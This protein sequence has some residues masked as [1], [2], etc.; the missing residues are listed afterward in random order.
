MK[1]LIDIL[2]QKI[3]HYNQIFL[4]K[5]EFV[6]SRDNMPN[7]S[8]EASLINIT[9]QDIHFFQKSLFTPLTTVEITFL[10][11]ISNL[12]EQQKKLI[13]ML[14]LDEDQKKII[15]SINLKIMSTLDFYSDENISK[16]E[17]E[18]KDY[19]VLLTKVKNN[20]MNLIDEWDLIKSLLDSENIRLEDKINIIID[21]NTKNLTILENYDSDLLEQDKVIEEDDLQITNLSEE[22]VREIFN[23]YKIDWNSIEPIFKEKLLKYGT[24]EKIEDILACLKDN[25]LQHIFELHEVLTKVLLFSNVSDINKVVRTLEENGIWHLAKEQPTIFF[26]SVKE[27]YKGVSSTRRGPSGKGKS[28]ISGSLTNFM[29]NVELLEELDISI[30]Y[31]GEKCSTFFIHSNSAARRTLKLL[32]LYGLKVDNSDILKDCIYVLRSSSKLL[33]RLDIAIENDCLEYAGSN[34][35]RISNNDVNFYRIKYAKKMYKQG[36][37][38]GELS[39]FKVYKNG[40]DRLA[41]SEKFYSRTNKIYGLNPDDTFELYGAVSYESENKEIYDGII[42]ASDNDSMSAMVLNDPIIQQLDNLYYDPINPFIYNFNGV[43]ISR[44]KVLRHYETLIMDPNIEPSY[45]LL[46]YVV[47]LFSMI[48]EKELNMIEECINKIKFVKGK[49][50]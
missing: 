40:S 36:N 26:P 16:L 43:I 5:E 6:N 7:L 15:Q 24:V 31:I 18:L 44:Y 2:E 37:Q 34:L 41:L 12:P 39:P 19:K 23:K 1:N 33:D 10:Q 4:K 9:E 49:I 14:G 27:K 11:K 17:E 50:K 48:D 45:D 30:D 8:T 47:T 42:K 25:N 21:L 28:V 46:M 20:S 35:S 13:L 22:R 3:A 29:K 38:L 32:K